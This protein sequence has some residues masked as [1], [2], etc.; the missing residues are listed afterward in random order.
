[1]FSIVSV[2]TDIK[3]TKKPALLKSTR[4]SSTSVQQT[5]AKTAE[6]APATTTVTSTEKSTQSTAHVS[7]SFVVGD[8]GATSYADQPQHDITV[9]ILAAL[10]GALFVLLACTAVFFL[11]WRRKR[12][13]SFNFQF[14][15]CFNWICSDKCCDT[16]H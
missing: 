16:G 15:L 7:T 5:T 10:A 11:L 2:V 14:S 3:P 6:T 4:T 13:T 12:Y 8:V 1:M 9:I